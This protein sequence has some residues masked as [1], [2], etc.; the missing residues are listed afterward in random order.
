MTNDNWLKALLNSLSTE[1]KL[2]RT[3]HLGGILGGAFTALMG[4][5][6][7][8]LGVKIA[9]N[10]INI[11]S[12]DKDYYKNHSQSDKKVL[13]ELLSKSNIQPILED[14]KLTPE[15]K[16][17]INTLAD[18]KKKVVALL[19]DKDF[20]ETKG[21]F[22]EILE[23]TKDKEKIS[24]SISNKIEKL[25]KDFERQY[26][27][28]KYS[29]KLDE[30][31]INDYR[32]LKDF[33]IKFDSNISIL[34]GENGS[35]KST[36]IEYISNVF[37]HLF[38]NERK[39]DI[40]LSEYEL[41]KFKFK[42]IFDKVDQSYYVTVKN[43]TDYFNP[44][45][46]TDSPLHWP[47]R[48][49]VSYSGITDRLKKMVKK[50]FEDTFVKNINS[51]GSKYSI[52]P[53]EF[54]LPKNRFYYADILY[55][56]FIY[57][58]LLFS[59]NDEANNLLQ[60]INVDV[61]DCEIKFVYGKKYEKL[62][63]KL[64]K[65][66][67]GDFFRQFKNYADGK[68]YFVG[69]F[70]LQDMFHLFK[71]DI[72][73]QEVFDIL[74]YLKL[75]DLISDIKIS[76]KNESGNFDLEHI[77]EGQKQEL[78]TLGLSLVFDSPN[79]L[80]L[81]DEPDTYLHPKWQREF[82]SSLAKALENGGCA[83]VTTHSPLLLGNAENAQVN[84]LNKGKLVNNSYKYFGKDNNDILYELM[85]VEKR[86][87]TIQKKLEQLSDLLENE[88]LEPSEKL[89]NELLQILG[90]D[91]PD[92]YGYKLMLDDLKEKI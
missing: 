89:Y 91:D 71:K 30:I 63:D 36:F 41:G 48:F 77:S 67:A 11:L 24:K 18:N 17:Q 53:N 26:E 54:Y 46:E 88:D 35:G 55:L 74:Y 64:G 29:F 82:I 8:P 23:E 72:S 75:N 65:N 58:A 28:K 13:D 80:F 61:A 87:S 81:F 4:P 83:I 70:S 15:Q 50:Y 7:F 1:D 78:M 3:I 32:I 66:I 52:A 21:Q 84:I 43:E 57:C 79:T 69:M 5:A 60:K 20:E 6:G 45:Y 25:S 12:N 39:K 31:Y 92:L 76:W 90:D 40:N 42:Y 73:S 85:G 22:V 38:L 34:I 14:G 44:I 27:S 37:A 49:V 9:A 56:N 47:D 86:I 62:Q 10:L 19:T 16:E 33:K 68:N 51:D 59:K 2:I